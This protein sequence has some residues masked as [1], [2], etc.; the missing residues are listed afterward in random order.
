VVDD[1]RKSAHS[2]RLGED[3]LERIAA[4]LSDLYRMI[5]EERPLDPHA[6]LTGNML[7]FVFEDG[8]TAADRLLLR[9]GRVDRLCEFRQ[10]FLDVIGDE[11]VAVVRDL[12]E[13]PV[14]YN[15][16][17]FDPK[18]RTTHVVFVLDLS[19]LRGAEQRQAVLNWSEQVRR[20]ARR[21]RRQH[22]A[23]RE[24]H[25]AL[26]EQM[27]EARDAARRTAAGDAV[28]RRSDDP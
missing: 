25:L 19:E 24:I 23:T 16:S 1:P 5:Y 3:A 28:A 21:L 4:T 10:H 6:S 7:A 14:T 26:K 15:F 17:G 22:Q 2:P 18:T 20:N 12:T 9:N 11:M 27:L 8:L 13:V